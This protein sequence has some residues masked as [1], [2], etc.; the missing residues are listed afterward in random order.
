MTNEELNSLQ[1]EAY[2]HLW[3]GRHRLALNS[4]VK[5]CEFRPNDSEA[6][7]CAAWA[8][9]EN[10][11]PL[12]ALEFANL[13]VE[14]KGDSSRTRFF[15]AYL[16]TRMSIY[17]GA[18]ADIEKSIAVITNSRVRYLFRTTWDKNLLTQDNLNTIEDYL[19]KNSNFIIQDCV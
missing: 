17:E 12:K 5:L 7:I 15:R 11:N 13:A 6:V 2:D 16:L 9:L 3:H 10:G 4:A 1:A 18:I 14:L 8:Y 19:P